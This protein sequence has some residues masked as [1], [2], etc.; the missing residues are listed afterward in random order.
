[1]K[2]M[3]LQKTRLTVLML[4]MKVMMEMM[5]MM[6]MILKP[7]PNNNLMSKAIILHMLLYFA[8]LNTQFIKCCFV[9]ELCMF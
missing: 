7:K 2:N 1:M 4:M 9:S 3:M 6:V 8:M 5:V